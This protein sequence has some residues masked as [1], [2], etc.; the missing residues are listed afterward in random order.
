MIQSNEYRAARRD[1]TERAA[2]YLDVLGFINVIGLNL[3]GLL[4]LWFAPRIRARRSGVRIATMWVCGVQAALAIVLAGLA[5][6]G[7]VRPRFRLFGQTLDMP[8]W[9]I[10]A[11]L[12]L[13][14]LIFGVPVLLL[15]AHGTREAFH[16]ANRPG[17]CPTCGYDLRAHAGPV[18]GM[19]ATGAE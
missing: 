11:G 10:G 15:G 9:S 4:Y 1:F 13:I 18:S 14:A 16:R 12:V 2:R 8:A 19:R 17:L 6:A 7:V 5:T 3:G